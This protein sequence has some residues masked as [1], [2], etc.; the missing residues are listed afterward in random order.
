MSR[1]VDVEPDD[2]TMDDVLRGP[3]RSMKRDE[4]KAALREHF[5]AGCQVSS[6]KGVT[7]DTPG[8]S[9]ADLARAVGRDPKDQ[10]VRRALQALADEGLV[11]QDEDTRWRSTPTLFDAED[12]S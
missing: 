1:V 11:Q 5:E 3:E 9:L 10:T 7:P 4:V 8:F 2:S 6:P 12:E